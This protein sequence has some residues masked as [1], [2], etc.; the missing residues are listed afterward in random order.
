[1]I[2][3]MRQLVCVAPILFGLLHSGEARAGDLRYRY[4]S[5]DNLQL[6]DGFAGFLF[7]LSTITD[8][9]RVYGNLC[10]DIGI[11]YAA[12]VDGGSLKVLQ[13][14][15][16]GTQVFSLATARKG[17][18]L[19]GYVFDLADPSTGQAAI[20]R[21]GKIEVVP[22]LPAVPFSFVAAFTDTSALVDVIGTSGE[23]FFF[24]ERGSLTPLDLSGIVNP[25]FIHVNR[26]GIVAGTMGSLFQDARA[27]RLDPNTGTVTRLDPLPIEP[28]AWGLG[29]NARGDV[30]GYSFVSGQTERIGIWDRQGRFQTYFVEG[31]AEFPTVSNQLLFN[32]DNLIAITQTTDGN[33]YI[34]PEPGV[35]LSLG[36]ITDNLP[37]TDFPVSF[38]QAMN[39]RQP[40]GLRVHRQSILTP[41]NRRQS[42]VRR[43]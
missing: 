30:L 9:D 11:C 32:D 4:I 22:G 18:L 15:Q 5:L 39:N 38:V 35:R 33:S 12:V 16:P 26:K 24:S 10:N 6:P 23:S 8:D 42:A 29:I 2:H 19:G 28:L 3:R 27:F 17:G 1:M 40:R 34:V 25:T 37:T 14:H 13:P 41:A 36:D 31:T 43:R 20:L 7:G 21:E